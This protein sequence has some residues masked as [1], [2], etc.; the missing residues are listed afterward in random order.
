MIYTKVN[1]REFVDCVN[2]LARENDIE[3]EHCNNKYT[4]IKIEERDPE[5]YRGY[6]WGVAYDGIAPISW[7]GEY[8]YPRHAARNLYTELK[9]EHPKVYTVFWNC[10][11]FRDL[12]R[13]IE[14]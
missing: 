1:L 10:Q 2:E 8:G 12:V 6:Q 11:R 13:D 14:R 3:F 5:I 7:G 9:R 4:Y